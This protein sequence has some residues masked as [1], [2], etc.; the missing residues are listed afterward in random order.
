MHRLPAIFLF[1]LLFSACDTVGEE[2]D[3]AVVEY[4]GPLITESD[5]RPR[6]GMGF[7][8][9]WEARLEGQTMILT[10]HA[11]CGDECSERYRLELQ[12]IPDGLP[13]FDSASFRRKASDGGSP[14]RVTDRRRLEKGQVAI[15][16]WNVDGVVSGEVTGDVSFVFW[17][18]FGK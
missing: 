12:M 3:V 2:D 11:M 14:P 8:Q 10:R 18:D 1:C 16:D 13:Q 6:D 15:Q 7:R 4:V 5:A 17:Y 9:G